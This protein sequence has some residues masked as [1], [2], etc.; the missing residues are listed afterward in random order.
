VIE[1]FIESFENTQGLS[2]LYQLDTL[3]RECLD[4]K[5]NVKDNGE[6]IVD[7]ETATVTIVPAIALCVDSQRDLLHAV[8]QGMIGN[9]DKMNTNTCDC[10]KLELQKIE[11]NAAILEGFDA[12]NM[13]MSSEQ[14]ED[15]ADMKGLFS[16]I[17]EFERKIGKIE[18]ASCGILTT[19]E[20]E[21]F[22]L[23]I[24]ILKSGGLSKKFAK[25]EKSK[26][27]DILSEKVENFVKCRVGKL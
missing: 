3:D 27:V 17:N 16:T 20:V 14:C 2:C 10:F 26:L 8:I 25:S 12:D 23:K 15:V 18:E 5:L 24:P 13:T 6:K 19:E 22:M 21:K 7:E 1:G 9:L 4:G 11:P